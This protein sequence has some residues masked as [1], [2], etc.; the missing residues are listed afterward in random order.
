M[1]WR[2]EASELGHRC[3]GSQSSLKPIH[4]DRGDQTAGVIVLPCKAAKCREALALLIVQID[5]LAAHDEQAE[6]AWC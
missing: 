5:G 3:S 1:A 4:A 6:N 2:Y